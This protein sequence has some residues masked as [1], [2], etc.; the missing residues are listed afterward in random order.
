MYALISSIAKGLNGDVRWRNVSVGDMLVHSI[1]STYSKVIVTLNE[2]YSNKQVAIDLETIKS[3]VAGQFITFNEF[4]LFNG[5]DTLV[6]L[7]SVPKL[8]TKYAQYFD[9]FRAGYKFH[10][11]H[12]SAAL[13]SEYPLSEKTWLHITRENTDYIKMHNSCLVNVN[14]FYHMTDTDGTCLYA[15]DATKS[16]FLSKQNQIGF[17]DF[18]NLGQLSLI[19]IT[20]DMIL[21]H[22][23]IH[24]LRNSCHI[25]LGTDVSNKTVMLVLGGYLH[26][27]DTRTFYR[28]NESVF[29]IDFNNL[30]LIDRYFESRYYIDLSSL[31][32][33]KSPRNPN[34]ISVDNFF[35]DENLLA[36]LTLSQSFFVILDNSDIFTDRQYIR[37]TNMPNMFISFEEPKSPLIVGS[38]KVSNYWY[39]LEDGQYSINSHDAMNSNRVY[40]TV[41]VLK[42][43]SVTDA[44][45]PYNPVSHSNAFLHKVGCDFI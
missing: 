34:Q 32:L 18:S 10:P 8:N 33:E 6:T 7:E 16:L 25:H 29:G 9:G 44:R 22:E 13:D 39:Q 38:G 17:Y 4:L 2:S 23:N 36:Y 5:D 43:V 37:A 20:T 11:I 42:E 1:F 3:K 26:V 21:N 30:N 45:I 28:L 15:K 35:N 19:P 27:L 40:D 31:P 41:D 12:P 24:G 14:G